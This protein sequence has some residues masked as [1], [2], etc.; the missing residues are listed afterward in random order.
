VLADDNANVFVSESDGDV[1]GF[2]AIVIHADGRIG[3]ISMLAVAPEHQRHGHG[4]ALTAFATDW[5][6]EQGVPVAMVE[7]GGDPGHA[8]ARATYEDAGFTL[9]PVARYFKAL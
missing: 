9:S 2:V 5:I 3:E 8:P 4:A 6:R 7:T 1:A